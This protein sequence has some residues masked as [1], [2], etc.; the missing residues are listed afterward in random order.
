V[1]TPG[2]NEWMDCNNVNTN[3]NEAPMD[4]LER[5]A[6]LRELFFSEDASLGMNPMPLTTQRQVPGDATHSYPENAR[7]STEGV[8]FATINA[9]GPSDD[10]PNHDESDPRRMANHEWLEAAFDQAEAT[11]APAVMIIWQA[12]PWY[13][14][15]TGID[16]GPTWKYLIEK[17]KERALAFGKPVVLVHGDTHVYRID[18]PWPDVPN[19]TRVETH[20]LGDSVNWIRATVD[21]S[22]PKVFSFANE[23][24]G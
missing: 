23:H 8:V 1:Y 22:D 18:N 7:W 9:P 19:F 21:P 13:V 16:F 6:K 14:S 24:A 3:P 4:S 17:L 2:D 20:A 11:N 10:V 15:P 12:D 5:L